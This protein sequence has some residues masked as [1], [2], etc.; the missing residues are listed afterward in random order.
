MNE[1]LYGAAFKCKCTVT[2]KVDFRPHGSQLIVRV[3][4]YSIRLQHLRSEHYVLSLPVPLHER[5][6]K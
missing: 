5:A 1:G 4:A 6:A 2:V 3:N